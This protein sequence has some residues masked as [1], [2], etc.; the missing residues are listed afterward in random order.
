[1]EDG[2]CLT[3]PTDATRARPENRPRPQCNRQ[4]PYGFFIAA[5]SA[6]LMLSFVMLSFVMLSALMAESEVAG[7]GAG[8]I[9][10]DESTVAPSSF[11]AHAAT[12]NTAATSTKRFITI[13][14]GDCFPF[15]CQASSA[16]ALNPIGGR[17]V[18]PGDGQCQGRSGASKCWRDNAFRHLARR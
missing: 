1:V 10:G 2:S 4:K 12:A 17:E 14:L 7:A 15:G 3:T 13:S 8:A 6:F 5:L 9:A 18:Y 16:S 11:F